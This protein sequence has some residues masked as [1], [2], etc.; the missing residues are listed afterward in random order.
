MWPFVEGS[1]EPDAFAALVDDAYATFDDPAVV[2]AARPGRR[3]VAGRAVP[4]PDA[5]V[6]GRRPAAG[7]PAVRPRADPAGRQGH[8]R[9]G[10]VGRHRLGGHRGLPRPRLDRDRD[11]AP[12][13]SGVRRAAPADDH[14]RLAQRAQLRGRGHLRRL[15]GPREG[16][17]RRRAVPR[18]GQPVGGQLHQLG[19]GDGP[20]RLL[21]EHRRAAHRGRGA[22]CPSRCRPATSATCS[23]ATAR[24]AWACPSRSSWSAATP[25]TSS[26]ASSRAR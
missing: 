4:R 22:R 1:I 6:Q 19:P 14:G 5:G 23:P 11:P 18:P 2:P 3:H 8:H 17:V 24:S 15:P 21:R 26:P 20:D 12:G 13:R 7:R 10:H 25:T 16:A 9:R